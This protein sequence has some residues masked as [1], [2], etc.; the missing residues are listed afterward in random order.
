MKYGGLNMYKYKSIELISHVLEK[1]KKFHIYIQAVQKLLS[2]II[3]EA[4]KNVYL[5]TSFQFHII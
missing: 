3:I 5:D 1:V 2:L 4:C